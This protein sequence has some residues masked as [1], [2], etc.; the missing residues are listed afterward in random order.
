MMFLGL[1][2]MWVAPA[3]AAEISFGGYTWTVRSG[4]GGPGPNTWAERNVW[5]DAA[6]NLHLK[7]ARAGTNWSCA[8]V[9]MT[10]R[11]GYGRYQ[12]QTLGRVDRLDENVVLGLFNYPTGD[13]GPDA[14]NEI[15]IEYARWGRAANPIGNFTVWPVAVHLRQTTKGFPFTLAG[16]ASTH[17]FVWSPDR[18]RFQCLD[19]HRDDDAGELA[20]WTYQPPDP[21]RR[22]ATKPMPVHLNLWLFQGRPPKNGAEVEITIRSFRF[23]PEPGA[24]GDRPSPKS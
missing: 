4:Q 17:R 20:A 24:Q 5:L 10:R 23:T 14:S 6:G 19:G 15:D 8:E 3:R 16:E 21:A 13:V 11:L 2:L 18:I 12:F 9:T 1:A 7:I 22:I